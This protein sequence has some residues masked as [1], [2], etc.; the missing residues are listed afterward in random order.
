MGHWATEDVNFPP[1]TIDAL[2]AKLRAAQVKFEFH[3]YHAK[4]G[5]ANETADS[6]NLAWLKY[7]SAAAD[8]AWSRTR[9]F[10]A[11]HLKSHH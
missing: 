7:D 3:R 5:F 10:L 4:H 6:K 9:D 1:A 2:E 11:L 8:L